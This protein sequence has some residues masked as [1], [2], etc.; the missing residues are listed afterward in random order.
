MK[1]YA[2]VRH[3]GDAAVLLFGSICASATVLE[4]PGQYP[5]IAAALV[6]ADNADVILIAPGAYPARVTVNKSVTLQGAGVG[7][8]VL[9]GG[10]TGRVLVIDPGS[11][12]TVVGV[13]ITN[14]RAPDDFGYGGGVFNNGI[15]RL[16]R[17]LVAGNSAPTAGGGVSNYDGILTLADSAISGNTA[18]IGGGLDNEGLLT[19]SACTISGNTAT[20]LGG[21]LANLDTA[22]LLNCTVA[23]NSAWQ[24]GGIYNTA[25]AIGLDSVTVSDNTAT[26]GGGISAFGTVRPVSALIAGNHAA[27]GIDVDGILESQGYNLIGSATNASGLVVSDRYGT[28]SAPLDAALGPLQANGGYTHTMLPGPGSPALDAGPDKGFPAQDQRGTARPLDGDADGTARAD[29]GACEAAATPF[30]MDELRACLRTAAGA[31]AA[32]PISVRRLGAEHEGGSAGRLDMLDAVRIA[33]KVAGL[34]A[35]P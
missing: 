29:I 14:G 18:P 32:D 26:S 31:N 4:V 25:D 1:R 13:T 8:T 9:D 33:R 34:E 6:A 24:G 15:L 3:L 28:A 10:G 16:E 17:C 21:G 11:S 7:Q 12:A 22:A 20:I 19:A 23:G 35:N 5:T 30:T 27:A 2:R